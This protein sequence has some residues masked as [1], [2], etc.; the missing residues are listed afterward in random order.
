MLKQLL[1]V[2]T[3]ASLVSLLAGCIVVHDHHRMI[4][5][6]QIKKQSAPGQMKKH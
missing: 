1:M 2:V 3:L 4:P 6:G 5:P